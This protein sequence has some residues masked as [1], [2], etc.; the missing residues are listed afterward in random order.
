MR[1][2]QH[3]ADLRRGRAL[4]CELADLIHDLFGCGFEPGG[5]RAGVGYRAGRDAF[6][7]GVETTHLLRFCGV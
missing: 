3:D 4:L 1:V 7:V 5:G 2:P 6:A